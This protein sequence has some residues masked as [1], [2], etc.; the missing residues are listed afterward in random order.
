MHASISTFMGDPDDVLARY[1]A[2]AIAR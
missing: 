2:M 1:D